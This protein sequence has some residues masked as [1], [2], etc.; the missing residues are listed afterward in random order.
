M[1][2]P[3][4]AVFCHNP[5]VLC[6]PKIY[7]MYVNTNSCFQFFPHCLSTFFFLPA[8]L[9]LENICHNQPNHGHYHKR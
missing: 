2:L 7:S 4:L 8:C 5:S 1:G 3:L 6:N 9:F